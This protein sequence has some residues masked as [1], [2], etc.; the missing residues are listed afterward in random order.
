MWGVW[1]LEYLSLISV[2]YEPSDAWCPELVFLG[3]AG[4]EAEEEK[5]SEGC[6]CRRFQPMNA[7][8]SHFAKSLLAAGET[9]LEARLLCE[10]LK[11]DSGVPDSVDIS[12]SVVE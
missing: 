2:I 3:H 12:V 11:L 6:W 9:V 5:E 8:C 4:R 1:L 7:R 10:K